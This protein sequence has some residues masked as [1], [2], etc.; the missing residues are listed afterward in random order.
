M[1]LTRLNNQGT[2]MK[3][4]T[5]H[6]LRPLYNSTIFIDETKLRKAVRQSA[7]I[8]CVGPLGKFIIDPAVWLKDGQKMKKVF[9]RPNQPMKLRGMALIKVEKPEK[10]ATLF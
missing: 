4:H 7:M 6:Y 5:H 9:R 8:E 3:L 10:V 1:F 2:K